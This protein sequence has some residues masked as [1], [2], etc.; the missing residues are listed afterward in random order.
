MHPGRR[1]VR[2]QQRGVGKKF[3]ASSLKEK[4]EQETAH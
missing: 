4:A 2:I 3:E 1:R